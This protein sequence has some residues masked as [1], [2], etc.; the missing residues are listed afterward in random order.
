M[1]PGTV[2]VHV[3]DCHRLIKDTAAKKGGL[4]LQSYLH[5]FQPEGCEAPVGAFLSET[6]GPL[7]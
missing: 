7:R 3:K 1:I 4:T 6:Q 5:D 2:Q